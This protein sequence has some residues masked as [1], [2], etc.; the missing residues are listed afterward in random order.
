M[1]VFCGQRFHEDTRGV[2]IHRYIDVSYHCARDTCI[3]S[4]ADYRD[5]FVLERLLIS[6]IKIFNHKQKIQMFMDLYHRLKN[7]RPMQNYVG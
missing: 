7:K 5:T 4:L 1:G 2:E 6:S 3:I